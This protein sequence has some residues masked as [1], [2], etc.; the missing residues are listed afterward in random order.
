M[1]FKELL[2]HFKINEE[3]PDYL[4]EESFNGIFL[5]GDFSKTDNSYKIEI[6]TRQDVTH[7]MI[8][9]PQDEFPVTVISKLPNGLKN[10]IR[11]GHL[12]GQ[13]V[14]INDI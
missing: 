4:L 12:E 14:Y 8:I 13:L 9:S 10:G 11:F 3:F 5:E 6:T 7:T 2:A 1:F